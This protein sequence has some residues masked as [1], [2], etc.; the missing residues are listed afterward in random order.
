MRRLLVIL[1]ILPVSFLAKAQDPARFSFE[2]NVFLKYDK[3]SPPPQ[4]CILFV[5][6]STIRM[7]KSLVPDFPDYC[8]I[9]RGFGGSEMSDLNYYFKDIVAP[10][11]PQIV[12]VYEGDND[13]ADGKTPETV[14]S[15][16]KTFLGQMSRLPGVPVFYLSAKPSP[17]RWKLRDS[18]EKLN[19]LIMDYSR[20]KNDLYFVDMFKPMLGENGR[21]KP[22]LFV[23]DSLHMSPKGYDLWRHTLDPVLKKY[24]DKNKTGH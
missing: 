14:L 2:I 11:R 15:D 21:P 12:V 23:A 6:S 13:L 16:F 7:W 17:S 3:D 18:Y 19:G 4:G 10:Y 20:G 24:Y 1:A 5:G 22:E 9:N 8:V